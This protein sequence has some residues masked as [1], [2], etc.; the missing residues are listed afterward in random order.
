MVG[1]LVASQFN[2]AQNWAL[3]SAMAV[4]LILMILGSVAI[5]AAVGLVVRA[6]IRGRRRVDIVA[7]PA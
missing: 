4:I 5:F 3:G 6:L 1:A 2:T 7:E